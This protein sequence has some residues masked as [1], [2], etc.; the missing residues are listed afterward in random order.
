MRAHLNA[1]LAWFVS[2]GVP[3]GEGTFSEATCSWLDLDKQEQRLRE[4]NDL[5]K[6]HRTEVGIMTACDHFLSSFAIPWLPTPALQHCPR[7]RIL[8]LLP[9]WRVG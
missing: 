5:P 6:A 1:W 8:L 3:Q 7:A 2:W 9:M 4:A